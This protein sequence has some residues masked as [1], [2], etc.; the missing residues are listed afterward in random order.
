M[1]LLLELFLGIFVILWILVP[2]LF[3]ITALAGPYGAIA[4]TS[5][6]KRTLPIAKTIIIVIIVL[7][8]LRYFGYELS[9]F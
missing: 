2:I 8:I 7:A 9:I 5:Y 4:C 3:I 1:V 6:L